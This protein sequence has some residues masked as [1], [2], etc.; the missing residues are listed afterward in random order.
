MADAISKTF[1]IVL[2]LDYVVMF[3]LLLHWTVRTWLAKPSKAL[4]T[5]SSHGVAQPH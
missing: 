2:L 3:G 1:V 5:Q 4:D